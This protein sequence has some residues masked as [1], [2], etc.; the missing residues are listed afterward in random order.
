MVHAVLPAFGIALTTSKYIPSGTNTLHVVP[1]T[2]DTGSYGVHVS[3]HVGLGTIKSG[4][5]LGAG[6]ITLNYT[7]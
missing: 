3:A 7:K 5:V 6:S 4:T 1:L 2:T